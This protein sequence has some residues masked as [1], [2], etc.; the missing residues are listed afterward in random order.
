MSPL[1]VCL[2][3]STTSPPCRV[4]EL[5]ETCGFLSLVVNSLVSSVN[6]IYLPCSTIMLPLTVS[7]MKSLKQWKFF[8]VLSF[9][10]VG[11]QCSVVDCNTGTVL[12]CKD[13][14]RVSGVAASA[15]SEQVWDFSL[16]VSPSQSR[17]WLRPPPLQSASSARTTLLA[18]LSTACFHQHCEL[19]RGLQ[20]G[21]QRGR[22]WTGE[23]WTLHCTVFVV[24]PI[25]WF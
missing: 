13:W 11:P 2:R 1:S 16:T 21:R 12:S 15:R 25:E 23:H 14:W 10:V 3:R 17:Y 9:V 8:Y 20:W 18:G 19:C 7:Y 4:G 22:I 24:W 6:P 5:P